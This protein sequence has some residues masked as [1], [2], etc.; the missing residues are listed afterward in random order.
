MEA[1]H[2]LKNQFVNLSL[3]GHIWKLKICRDSLHQSKIA[4]QFSPTLT[5]VSKDLPVNSC[6]ID[7]KQ[8]KIRPRKINKFFTTYSIFI[9]VSDELHQS[10]GYKSGFQ[11]FV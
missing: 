6:I 10:E 5:M 7:S 9:N 4:C 3:L 1:K 8:E 11:N 2:F